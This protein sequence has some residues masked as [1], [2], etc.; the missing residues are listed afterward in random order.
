MDCEKDRIGKLKHF[1]LK[2]HGSTG[3]PLGKLLAVFRV[4]MRFPVA[5]GIE[6]VMVRIAD[7][8]AVA[9]MFEHGQLRAPFL[10]SA[11]HFDFFT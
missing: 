10:E 2:I 3:L 1:C 7:S 4:K 11:V 6:P 5:G 8:A 9:P